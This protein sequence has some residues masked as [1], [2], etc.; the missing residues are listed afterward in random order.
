MTFSKALLLSLAVVSLSACSSTPSF[1]SPSSVLLA[2]IDV[3]SGPSIDS[4]TGLSSV[5]TPGLPGAPGVPSVD[6]P[7]LPG[8]PG[9]PSV[10]APGLPSVPAIPSIGSVISASPGS[11]SVPGLSAA[12]L[13]PTLSASN[14]TC[15]QFYK[16]TANFVSLPSADVSL[17]SA[18]SGP[19]FGGTLLKT[20]VLGTLSGVASGGV[21]ALG[22]GNSF[23]EAAL[24][25]T[26][27]QVTYNTGS[28]VY[29]GIVGKSGADDVPGV[30]DVPALTPMQEI[31]K[32]A[33]TLGCP[34]PDVASIAALGL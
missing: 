3:P 10:D 23:A 31:T 12:D 28:T 19:S 16:N 2:G 29:D 8:A 6:V 17:P 9:V 15:L 33:A 20:L 32:A 13:V 14:P 27:S 25:G 30:A 5:N 1:T 11:V 4:T 24:I 7:G 18:P 34:A 22:I 21:A 26:V